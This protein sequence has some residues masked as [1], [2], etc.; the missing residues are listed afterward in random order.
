MAEKNLTIAIMELKDKESGR[1]HPKARNNK[2][3]PTHR[4]DLPY[5]P[6]SFD[7]FYTFVS[8]LLG[9]VILAQAVAI[10]M[11]H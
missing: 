2:P 1:S 8:I 10:I 5:R 4:G 7:T 6:R 9:A 3:Q 11:Y